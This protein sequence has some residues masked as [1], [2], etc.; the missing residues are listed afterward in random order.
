[1]VDKW[2]VPARCFL[3]LR[4]LLTSYLLSLSAVLSADIKGYTGELRLVK[5]G[6]FL[7]SHVSTAA[8]A[9]AQVRLL[10]EEVNQLKQMQTIAGSGRYTGGLPVVGPNL[11]K[12]TS[13]LQLVA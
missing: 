5:G 8:L 12:F 4:L 11:R 13:I 9:L 3:F 6:P 10:R 1:M 7:S 2:F